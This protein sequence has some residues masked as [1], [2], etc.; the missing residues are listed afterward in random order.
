MDD[1]DEG[2]TL[3]R[4]GPNRHLH[5]GGSIRFVGKRE[6]VVLKSETMFALIGAA[7]FAPPV[8]RYT[9]L[10][11]TTATMSAAAAMITAASIAFRNGRPIIRPPTISVASS[12]PPGAHRIDF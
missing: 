8:R 4:H 10:T 12:G 11:A 1:K 6:R 9:S 2:T 3:H 5:R 7:S